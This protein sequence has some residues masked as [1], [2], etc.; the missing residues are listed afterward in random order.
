M[1][2]YLGDAPLLFRDLSDRDLEFAIESPRT[3]GRNGTGGRQL[4]SDALWC[5]CDG[6]EERRRGES[7]SELHR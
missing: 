7:E 4:F 6:T 3:L 2:P 5:G 1:T